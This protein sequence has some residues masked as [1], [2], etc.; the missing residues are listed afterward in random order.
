MREQVCC[1][2]QEGDDEWAQW[3]VGSLLQLG[4]KLLNG[5]CGVLRGEKHHTS[6]QAPSI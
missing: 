2:L 1:Y 5:Q 3:E 6:A 4:M